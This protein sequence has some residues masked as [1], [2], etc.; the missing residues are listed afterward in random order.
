MAVHDIENEAPDDVEF[1]FGSGDASD[2]GGVAGPGIDY[3]GSDDAE[4]VLEW[5]LTKYSPNIALATSFK[6]AV[7]IHMMLKIRPDVRVFALDTGRMNEETYQCAEDIQRRLKVDI[8][9][10]FPERELVEGLERGKGMYSFRESL[11]NRKECCYVR[12]VEPLKRALTGLDAWIT[13]VRRDQGVTRKTVRKIEIDAAHGGIVKINPLADWGQDRIWAYVKEHS[14]PYNKLFDQGYQSIGCAPC[15]RPV[16]TGEDP[17]SGR[18]WW[19]SA[20]HKECGIHI[21][22]FS[23]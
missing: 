1:T 16:K 14:L 17:R 3:T 19:E 18:W 5:A 11:E 13:G 23:I 10:V 12:K 7:L 22:D 15:T 20:E 9:W 8:E 4:A 2:G 21:P 6:D